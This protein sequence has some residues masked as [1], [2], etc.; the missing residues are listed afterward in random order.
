MLYKRKSLPN[1]FTI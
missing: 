1:S